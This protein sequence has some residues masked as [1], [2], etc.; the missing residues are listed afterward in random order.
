MNPKNQNKFQK[1]SFVS[2]FKIMITAILLLAVPVVN[3]RT[4]QINHRKSHR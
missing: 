3:E 4:K 2:V 1:K